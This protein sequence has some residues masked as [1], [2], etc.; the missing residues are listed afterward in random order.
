MTFSGRAPEL[1]RVDP[2]SRSPDLSVNSRQDVEDSPQF[3]LRLAKST[4]PQR[5]GST[6]DGTSRPSA[7]DN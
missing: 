7:M 1:D 2:D 5:D 4:I 6:H 3:S